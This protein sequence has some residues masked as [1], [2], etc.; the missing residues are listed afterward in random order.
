MA[1]MLYFADIDDGEETVCDKLVGA[2]CLE[3]K[4]TL[5]TYYSGLLV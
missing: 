2:Q 3:S 5:S 1:E 4:F